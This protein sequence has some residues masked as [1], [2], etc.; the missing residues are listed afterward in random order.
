MLTIGIQALRSTTQIGCQSVASSVA[1]ADPAVPS[2][3]IVNSVRAG[4][5]PC[6]RAATTGR[7]SVET[8][9]SLNQSTLYETGY[10]VQGVFCPAAHHRITDK[11]MQH[12]D[13]ILSYIA[14]QS[15]NMAETSHCYRPNLQIYAVAIQTW[16]HGSMIDP[17]IACK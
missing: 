17:C 13:D 11:P 15:S 6:T 2:M 10:I 9:F 3:S 8:R 1:V 14:G 12:V 7:A 5:S 16:D 4:S